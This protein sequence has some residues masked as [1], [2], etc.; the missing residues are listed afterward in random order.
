[1]TST[2]FETLV[3]LVSINLSK[4][5]ARREPIRPAERLSVTLRYPVTGDAFSTIAHSYRMS[6]ASVGRIVKETCKTLRSRI[7]K[8][9]QIVQ[10]NGEILPRKCE[11]YWNFPNCVGAIDGK[12]VTIQCLQ[13][14]VLCVLTIKSSIAWFCWLWYMIDMNF[15]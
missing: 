6:D 14:E 5:N 11:K 1:M 8:S 7:Y 9:N 13:E 4:P 15:Q 10:L 12:H 2:K 3:G